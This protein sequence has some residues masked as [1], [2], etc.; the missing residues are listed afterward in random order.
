M[1]FSSSVK[2]ELCRIEVDDRCCLISELASVI[3][4]SGTVKP[5][6]QDIVNI[7]IVTENAAFA[8]RVFSIIKKLFGI[9]PEVLI[10]KGKKLKKHVSYM[11][12]VTDPA[13]AGQILKATGLPEAG[14]ANGEAGTET[15]GSLKMRRIAQKACCR[16]AFLRGAFLSGGSVTDPE[17]NYHLEIIN[18]NRE[19]A[20]NLLKHMG[21][22]GLN[23]KI[24]RRKGNFV[25]YLKEGEDIVDF[26]NVIGAHSA[27]M[28]L[29]NVRILKEMRN[30]VNRIVN[31]ETANLGKTVNA[32]LRQIENI[33]L[34]KEKIGFG[35]LPRSLREIAELRLEHSDASLKELGEMLNPPL[36]KSGVNHRL[37]KLDRIAEKEAGKGQL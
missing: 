20:Q 3:R 16:K 6:R 33:K 14:D 26:L 18:K 37:R 25:V 30:N 15:A 19:M 31:C 7:K 29:E 9:Y 32:S 21:G 23:A 11:I 2:N 12:V 35:N 24:I 1:S 22:Y 8:R 4:I 17:K 13:K 27:L 36:G 28:E 10:R 34:I 5:V